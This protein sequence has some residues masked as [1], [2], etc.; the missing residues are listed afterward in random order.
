MAS[1]ARYRDREPGNRC[2]NDSQGVAVK[3][4][5]APDQPADLARLS[6]LID[7]FSSQTILV[8][9]D[10]VADQ[11]IV[12]DISR[13]SREAPVLIVRKR[14]TQYRPGGGANAANN[15]ADLGAQVL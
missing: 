11:F 14:E 9:G 4:R 3:N 2:C 12:G 13:V 1:T 7:L 8:L 10:F 15:L 5:P 6:E